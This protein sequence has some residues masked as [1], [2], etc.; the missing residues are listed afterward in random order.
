MR[1]PK[2]QFLPLPAIAVAGLLL[3][4]APAAQAGQDAVTGTA[5]HLGA[6]PPYPEIQVHVSAHA[7]AT[8]ADPRGSLSVDATDIHSYTGDVT[9]LNVFGNQATI[10][11][12][13]VKSSDPSLVGQ[14]EL[15]S[16]VDGSPENPDL[17]AGYEITATPPATCPPLIFNVP[18]VNG[19]YTIR[20]A[21]P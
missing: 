8:G 10:G 17:I 18:V 7:D 4:L 13:I 19:N 5:R 9:C 3:A 1:F 12:Q 16:L 11:I 20:D 14:G 15:W 2:R 6:D 21:T